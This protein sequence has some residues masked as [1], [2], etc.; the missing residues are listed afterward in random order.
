M[1]VGYIVSLFQCCSARCWSKRLDGEEGCMNEKWN[2]DKTTA[3]CLNMS[4]VQ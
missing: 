3:L 2:T 4:E 1:Q